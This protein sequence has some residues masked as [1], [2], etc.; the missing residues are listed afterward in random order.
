VPSERAFHTITLAVTVAA[1]FALFKHTTLFAD[2][3]YEFWSLVASVLAGTGLHETL[4]RTVEYVLRRIPFLK[5]LI[6]GKSYLEGT[7][8]GFYLGENGYPR[9][10]IQTMRQEWSSVYING[11]AFTHDAIPHG[12][13]RSVSATVDGRAGLLHGVFSGDQSNGHYDSIFS[14]Q[15]EG[16]PPTRLSGYF[17]DSSTSSRV[18]QAWTIMDKVCE[19]D[20]AAIAKAR[21][22]YQHAIESG[23][24][25]A[26]LRADRGCGILDPK[27]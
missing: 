21:R 17:Y 22:L 3:N 20:R 26:S 6:L 11:Q 1:M 8:S 4:T 23:M 5:K 25:K 12:Q 14:F 13:W 18:G 27:E 15:L 9:F 10:V 7:W 19:R 2:D 16:E 24:I